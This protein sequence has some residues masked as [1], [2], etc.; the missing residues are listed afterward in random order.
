VIPLKDY[1][2]TRTTAWVTFLLIVACVAVYFFVQ[3]ASNKQ[4]LDQKANQFTVSEAA[5]PD[6]VTT[7]EPLSVQEVANT[8]PLA[9]T[10]CSGVE[11][12]IEGDTVRLVGNPDQACFRGKNVYVAVLVSMFLHGSL[13]HLGFNMLFLWIFGNNIEDRFGHLRHL[14]FYVAAGV[15]ATAYYVATSPHSTV[16]LVGASGAIAGVMGAYLMLWPRARILGLLGIFP[17]PLPAWLFLGFWFG[18]QFIG[19]SGS[20]AYGAHIGGFVFGMLVGLVVRTTGSTAG[21]QD[22][23]RI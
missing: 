4:M 21:R 2:P 1:N 16:P 13:G 11:K 14:A 3:P 19:S 20:V 17:I 10:A 8:D 5:I 23:V 12:R 22:Y 7:G 15:A 6:E 9:A 18:S